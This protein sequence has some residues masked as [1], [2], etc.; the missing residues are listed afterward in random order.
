MENGATRRKK[1]CL[2][3]PRDVLCTKE[4]FCVLIRSKA[5]HVNETDYV[6]KPQ[7]N[8]LSSIHSFLVF[9]HILAFHQCTLCL[10][11]DGQV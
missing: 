1:M 10:T 6:N 3:F 4:T 2:E 11:A 5:N 7:I 9:L 8:F